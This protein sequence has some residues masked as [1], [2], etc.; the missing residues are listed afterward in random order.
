MPTYRVVPF[1]AKVREGAPESQISA[2]LASVLE[3]QHSNG[4][5]LVEVASIPTLVMPGCLGFLGKPHVTFSTQLIF[6]R[7]E[8]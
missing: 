3:E 5:E 6:K 4:Y 2:Q 7:S 8:D 1:S